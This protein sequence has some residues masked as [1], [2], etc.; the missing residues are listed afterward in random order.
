MEKLKLLSLIVA[1]VTLASCNTNT[2][3]SGEGGNTQGGGENTPKPIVDPIPQKKTGIFWSD[4]TEITNKSDVLLWADFD[5]YLN[6]QPIDNSLMTKFFSE[7]VP[8]DSMFNKLGDLHITKKINDLSYVINQVSYKVRFKN[9]NI[10]K[11][12]IS[13]VYISYY[14]DNLGR[15][16][17][18][19]SNDIDNS[20]Y[21]NLN[22]SSLNLDFTKEGSLYSGLVYENTY[23]LSIGG[24][25]HFG[26]EMDYLSFYNLK[27][28]LEKQS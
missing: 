21:V 20:G 17:Y 5:D 8:N 18:L 2:G 7:N 15:R 26:T 9:S 24:S 10:T 12:N 22:I 14:S 6:P 23:R 25:V 16:V 19:T 1:M 11:D 13:S 27:I 28:V 3:G 4:G